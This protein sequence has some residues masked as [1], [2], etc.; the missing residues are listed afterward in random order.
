ME[1]NQTLISNHISGMMINLCNAEDLYGLF[2]N[3]ESKVFSSYK[4][5]GSI[6]LSIDQMEITLN[7]LIKEG[8]K[9]DG[10]IF[11]YY[12]KDDGVFKIEDEVEDDM[13]VFH[14]EYDGIPLFI[15]ID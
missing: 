9:K 13:E 1:K 2:F 10:K 4:E 15:G 3:E 14:Q 11:L 6:L 8:L 7:E 5:E 12:G